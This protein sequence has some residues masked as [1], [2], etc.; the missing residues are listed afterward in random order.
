MRTRVRIIGCVML[1]VALGAGCVPPSDPGRG[2]FAYVFTYFRSGGGGGVLLAVSED[3]LAFREVNGGQPIL[4]SGLG[5]GLTR[6]PSVLLGPDGRWHM[7]WT[8]GAEREVGIASSRDLLRWTRPRSVPVMAHEPTTINSWA[9]ELLWD[10]RNDR[11][12]IIYSSTVRRLHPEGT[13]E[14]GID[15]KPLEHR[16][17]VSYSKNLRRWSE[18]RLFW[19]NDVNVIDGVVV[20][21]KRSKR[22]ALVYKDERLTPLRKN[23]R[24]TFGPTFGGPWEEPDRLISEIGV[25]VEGPSLVRDD[26]GTGWLLYGDRY[27]E[28]F[29]ALASSPDLETW[30]TRTS[31]LDMPTGARHGTVLRVPRWRIAH[32]L[33]ERS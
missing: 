2:R 28:G 15:G 7:A 10:A 20:R 17:Y 9:P 18:G 11:Y 12:A 21:D 14:P 31:E 23:A 16:L 30:T 8:S 3:G 13:S 32:L 26:V 25:I 4:R 24:I 22:F 6:D 29:Y 33:D 19:D 27:V 5:L 1:L